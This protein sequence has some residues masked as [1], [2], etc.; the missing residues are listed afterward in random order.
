MIPFFT[1]VDSKQSPEYPADVKEIQKED[2]GVPVPPTV[3]DDLPIPEATVHPKVECPPRAAAHYC[4]N[5]G[6]CQTPAEHG[7]YSGIYIC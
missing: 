5:G 7:G 2:G 3:P 4:K 1:A 6:H